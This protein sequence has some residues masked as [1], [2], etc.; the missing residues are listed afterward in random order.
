MSL[1]LQ[2]PFKRMF[3]DKLQTAE[4]DP[5][6][7]LGFGVCAYRDIVFRMF[8]LFSLFSMMVAPQCYFYFKGSGY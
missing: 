3:D 2:N 6:V 8:T 5:L 1:E 4:T 7:K